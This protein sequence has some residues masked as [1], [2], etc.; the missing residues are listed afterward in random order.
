MQREA[1]AA[2]AADRTSDRIGNLRLGLALVAL[3]LILLPLITRDAG[4][5]WGLIVVFLGFLGLGKV[6]DGALERRRVHRAKERYHGDAVRRW[7]ESWRELPDRGADV[8]AAWQGGLHYADDL[9]LFGEAS[10]FQ[11]LSRAATGRGR[12]TVADWLCE[13]AS[14]D[15]VVARQGAARELV[16]QLESRADLYA[17]AAGEDQ[18][19]LDDAQLKD[20]AENHAPMPAQGLL[21]VVG[22]VLPLALIGTVTLYQLGGP[23]QPMAIA[24][25]VQLLVLFLLRGVVGPRVEVLSGPERTLRRAGG[26]IRQVERLDLRDP[27]LRSRQAPLQG[28][29]SE[30]QRL[31]RIVNLLDARLNVIF[32]LSVGPALMWDLNLVLRAEA[33]RQKNGQRLERWFAGIGDIEAV[34]SWAALSFERPDYGWP[35]LTSEPG[36]FEADGLSHPLIHREQ[37]VANHLALG[38][39]GSVLL[40]SGSNMSGKSTLLRAVGLA[41]VMARAGA[42]VAARS[43]RLSPSTLATSVRVVDSLAQGTSHFYAELKRLKFVVDEGGREGHGLLYLLDEVL[44]GTNSRERIIGA[45]TVIRWLSSQG[46]LGIVTTHD[47]GLAKVAQELPAGTVASRHFSDRV[48]GEGIAFDYRLREGPIQTTNAL[49]LMKA[50]GIDLDFGDDSVR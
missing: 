31:E 29:S 39:P 49:R 21:R 6:Q 4:P 26:L 23:G 41:V 27:W 22:V 24:I 32:A 33:W 44:H 35:E 48:A 18:A 42:P 36:R 10:L 16:D 34:A 2:D 28:A 25:M 45:T 30:V 47:L 7:E 37:V 5:W 9:D 46:A 19:V 11:L 43:L 40:L 17:A 8:G 13:P 14:T 12:R 50:V 3:L 38:G 15:E 20:W 1:A